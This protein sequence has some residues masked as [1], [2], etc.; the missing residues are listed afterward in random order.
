MPQTP[1]DWISFIGVMALCLY[2][3]I[4]EWSNRSLNRSKYSS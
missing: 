3:L 4:T 1:S 2:V